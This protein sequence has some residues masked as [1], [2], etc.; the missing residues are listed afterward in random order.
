MA[1]ATFENFFFYDPLVS[2]EVLF[3]VAPTE[4][5]ALAIGLGV[6]ISAAV[7]VGAVIAAMAIKP[8]RQRILPF[9]DRSAASERHA[10]SHSPPPV[11]DTSPPTKQP[12][13]GWVKSATP[14]Q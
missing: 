9:R 7:L 1:G 11:S 8:V 12:S 6:G 3:D 10:S 13:V 14:Q 4:S 2:I 5:S